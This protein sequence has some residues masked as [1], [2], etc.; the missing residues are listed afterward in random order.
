[1]ERLVPYLTNLVAPQSC[2][3]YHTIRL[4][5]K[6]GD[7]WLARLISIH[8][9]AICTFLPSDISQVTYEKVMTAP[10]FEETGLQTR[11][12]ELN[13]NE[14]VFWEKHDLIMKSIADVAATFNGFSITHKHRFIRSVFDNSL[15]Y[16][17]GVY[18]TPYLHSLFRHNELILRD[19][20]LLF[21]EQPVRKIGEKLRCARDGILISLTYNYL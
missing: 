11:L 15:S 10:K 5:N 18:R 9:D 6:S 2:C 4:M 3:A 1:M 17:D 7:D 16:A 14:Q 21:V 19:K 12:A 8:F 13:S 20:R